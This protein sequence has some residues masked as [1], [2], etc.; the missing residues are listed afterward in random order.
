MP[1]SPGWM[2]TES[3][4]KNKSK[5]MSNEGKNKIEKKNEGI[6]IRDQNKGSKIRDQK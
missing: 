5:R 1:S 2:M 4:M 6:K 3:N